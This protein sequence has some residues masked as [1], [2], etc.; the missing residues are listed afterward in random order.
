[1]ALSDNKKGL[2]LVLKCQEGIAG[3]EAGNTAIQA[4]KTAYQN[5]SPNPNAEGFPLTSQQVTDTSEMIDALNT[6]I[7]VTYAS[8]ISTIKGINAGSHK[9]NS[10]D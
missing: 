7:T 2:S 9:G 10:L 3:L 1:M 5:A 6:F 8:I 4:V